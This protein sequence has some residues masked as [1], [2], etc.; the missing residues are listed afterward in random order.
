M[1]DF[2][3][4]KIE[5]NRGISC[6]RFNRVQT[7]YIALTTWEGTIEIYDFLINRLTNKFTLKCPQ[8]TC[9]FAEN[10]CIA[11]GSDGAVTANGKVI[12]SHESPVSCIVYIEGTKQFATGSFDGKIKIWN[13]QFNIVTELTTGNKIYSMSCIDRYNVFCGCGDKYVLTIDARAPES[14]NL[15]PSPLSY[16]ISCVAAT[17]T[18]VAIGSFQGR[19][20]ISNLDNNTNYSFKA[21][22]HVTDNVRSIYSINAMKFHPKTK[23]LVTGGGDRKIFVWDIE[24]KNVVT[25]AG[26]FDTTISSLDISNDGKYLVAAI[27]YNFDNGDIEHAP[28]EVRIFK[29]I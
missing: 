3:I 21:H 28:D 1:E 15:I 20:C 26:P 5:G 27:S 10:C 24:R 19:I 9:E 16:D 2:S 6:I 17:D 11:G 12:G 29:F 14:G 7:K 23:Q 25:D 18:H 22:S 4:L 8:L 13:M